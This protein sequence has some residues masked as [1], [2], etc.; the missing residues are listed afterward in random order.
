MITWDDIFQLC[1][2]QWQPAL[3]YTREN[4]LQTLANQFFFFFF[5]QRSL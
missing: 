1:Q 2:S 5:E 4:L 3:I